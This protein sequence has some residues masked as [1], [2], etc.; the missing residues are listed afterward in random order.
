[1]PSKVPSRQ[2]VVDA[3]VMRSAGE[4]DHPVSSL[5]RKTLSDIL[6]I[7]HHAIVNDRLREEW[8]RHA[9]RR[10]KKWVGAMTRRGK[11]DT[12]TD[13][14]AGIS[15]T[16]VNSNDRT[17]IEKDRMLVDVAYGSGRII[18]STDDKIRLALER[19]G[20]EKFTREIRWFNPCTAPAG[21]LEHL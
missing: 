4:T 13:F 7:C 6:S 2:L 15:F 3:C 1:M 10:A 16:R 18:I 17:I 19:T 9:S 12:S 20:N 14:L 21:Y 11:I 8:G 5:C